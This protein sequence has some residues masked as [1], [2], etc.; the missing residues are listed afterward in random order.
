MYNIGYL[1]Y[2]QWSRLRWFPWRNASTFNKRHTSTCT[3]EHV[4]PPWWCTS[5][6]SYQVQNWLHKNF[7][8]RLIGQESVVTWPPLSAHLSLHHPDFKLWGC[9]KEIVYAMKV[10]DHDDLIYHNEVA[11]TNIRNQLRLLGAV[12][13]LNLMSL[14]GVCSGG[15]RT[16]E[17]LLQ[18]TVPFLTRIECT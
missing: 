17:H 11:V 6:F 12:R 7:L 9:V 10:Q 3:Q 8:D 4:V 1:G 13:G 14:W 16:F 2:S 5:H 15:G 18:C